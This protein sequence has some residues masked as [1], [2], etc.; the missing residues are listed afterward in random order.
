MSWEVGVEERSQHW[1]C[2]GGP[3]SQFGA[4][5]RLRGLPHICP[6]LHGALQGLGLLLVHL[7]VVHLLIGSDR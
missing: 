4:L 7:N 1:R 6:L 5:G 2:C 3:V